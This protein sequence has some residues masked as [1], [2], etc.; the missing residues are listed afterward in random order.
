MN[1]VE[2]KTLRLEN[3]EADYISF[4]S[5]KK[6]LIFIQGLSLRKVKG[7][8]PELLHRYSLF[9]RDYHVYLFDR[10]ERLQTTF[11]VEQMADDLA[12]CMKALHLSGAAVLGISQGGMIAQYLAIKHPELVSAM[13]LAVTASR[14]NPLTEAVIDRWAGFARDKNASAIAMD[15]LESCYS[16]KYQKKFRR[17]FSLVLQLVEVIPMDRFLVMTQACLTCHTYEQLGQIRCPV[18]VLG[19]EQDR[20]VGPEASREI[21]ARLSCELYMYPELG[22]AAYEEAGD[23]NQRVYAFFSE[24]RTGDGS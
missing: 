17:V 2:E 4:G 10:R 18:L 19:G 11:T 7:T 6:P 1:E 14:S 13:V 16:E 9:G 23:F 24:N 8:G 22:H 15:M 12:V 5:G 21:A 3:F 20:V